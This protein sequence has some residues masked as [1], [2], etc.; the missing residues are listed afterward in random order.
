MMNKYGNIMNINKD[1]REVK[2]KLTILENKKISVTKNG[3]IKKGEADKIKKNM[4]KNMFKI[5][6][7]YFLFLFFQ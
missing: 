1:V 3:I 6:L 4:V 2:N 7:P 5:G